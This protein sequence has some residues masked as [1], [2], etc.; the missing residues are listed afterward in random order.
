MSF[1]NWF[2]PSLGKPEL[3]DDTVGVLRMAN[4][5][6]KGASLQGRNKSQI[7]EDLIQ[8]L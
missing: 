3:E 8:M 5:L 6:L 2:Y 7:L 4:E 1:K